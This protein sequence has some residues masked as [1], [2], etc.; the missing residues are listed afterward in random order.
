M[1]R[2]F[3]RALSRHPFFRGGEIMVL[4][5]KESSRTE[6]SPEPIIIH[7]M[8]RRRIG[9]NIAEFFENLRLQGI[10]KIFDG[11]GIAGREPGFYTNA[12][13]EIDS[14]FDVDAIS[15]AISG[16]SDRVPVVISIDSVD[17]PFIHPTNGHIVWYE[18]RDTEQTRASGVSDARVC[19]VSYMHEGNLR[20]A[21]PNLHKI[22]IEFIRREI[23]YNL[24]SVKVIAKQLGIEEE[25][26]SA[27]LRCI[28]DRLSNGRPDPVLDSIRKDIN[29]M[30]GKISFICTELGID[31]A[32]D[33][34][35][36]PIEE[37][38]SANCTP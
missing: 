1:R 13:Y 37:E 23:S 6:K 22:F 10:V 33:F 18:S 2:M 29:K 16:D 31:L 20:I 26:T 9:D 3:H 8:N 32:D 15:G 7:S 25:T 27:R 14:F 30:L 35:L 19:L 4:I 12:F 36:L 28:V 38:I 11:S 5:D 17:P 34:T 24:E 21:D